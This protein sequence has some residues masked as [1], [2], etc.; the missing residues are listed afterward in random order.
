MIY[1]HK[2]R[3]ESQNALIKKLVARSY[4][5][6]NAFLSATIIKVIMLLVWLIMIL[7]I[8]VSN[9]CAF[10]EAFLFSSIM[11]LTSTK[12]QQ[13]KFGQFQK[14]NQQ[15]QLVLLPSFLTMPSSLKSRLYWI[16]SG[17]S[18]SNNDTTTVNAEM[19]TRNATIFASSLEHRLSTLLLT[20]K[21]QRIQRINHETKLIRDS[22]PSSALLN[23][24]PSSC[25]AFIK[26][27]QQREE[28]TTSTHTN[29][30]TGTTIC[31]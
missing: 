9:N 12:D 18:I 25:W 31:W 15:S 7:M 3:V 21:N 28:A 8:S 1:I 5:N 14:R 23:R 20:I 30:N 17:I 24:L 11:R 4:R 27:L 22:Q 29:T 16:S 26:I 13:L 10:V 19:I 6:R 2:N